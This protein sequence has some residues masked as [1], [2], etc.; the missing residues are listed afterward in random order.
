MANVQKQFEKFHSIIRTDYEMN[1][2]LREKRN[3]L[4]RRIARH[5]RK[6]S[7]PGFKRISQGSYKM[8]TGVVPIKDLEYDIDVGLRFAFPETEH[9][10]KEVRSWVFDA[11]KDHATKS[12]DEKGPC[13]RVTYADGYHVDLVTYCTW[14]DDAGEQQYRLAH[15][16]RGWVPARRCCI[17]ISL[18]T[19][20]RSRKPNT[21]L[22]GLIS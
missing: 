9:T 7:R 21:F 2:T 15:K 17:N 19:F 6:N 20:Y 22:S 14:I 18:T 12:V 10:A 13:I 11:V 5:L 3:I 4:L 8:K 1:A 16:T